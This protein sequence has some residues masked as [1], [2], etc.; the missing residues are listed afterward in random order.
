[1]RERDLNRGH[2][3]DTNFYCFLGNNAALRLCCS[4]NA[5]AS[6][7][8]TTFHR[9]DVILGSQL[10]YLV[11]ENCITNFMA[12][13][14]AEPVNCGNF[15]VLDC[16]VDLDVAAIDLLRLHCRLRPAHNLQSVTHVRCD[17]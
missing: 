10:D 5:L 6:E 14:F 7:L 12:C 13:D 1:M 3:S 9:F 4:Q 16:K 11:L 8:V 15:R 2:E 17:K